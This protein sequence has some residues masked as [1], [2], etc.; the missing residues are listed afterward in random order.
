MAHIS[1]HINSQNQKI[2]SYDKMSNII[3]NL[4]SK[5]GENKNNSTW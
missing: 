3:V 1:E 4:G 2:H 5:K